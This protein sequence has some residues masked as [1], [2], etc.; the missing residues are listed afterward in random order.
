MQCRRS[1]QSAQIDGFLGGLNAAFTN[2]GILDVTYRSADPVAAANLATKRAAAWGY[3]NLYWYRDGIDAW[4][5][6]RLPT[7]A[8]EPASGIVTARKP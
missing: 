7:A 1:A 4:E 5:A 3:M 8:A 6:A 2:S